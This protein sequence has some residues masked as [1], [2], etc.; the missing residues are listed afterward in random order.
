[1]RMS[2]VFLPTI[3]TTAVERL[4]THAITELGNLLGWI[5]LQAREG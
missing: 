5:S 4:G 3:M 1:M 2:A